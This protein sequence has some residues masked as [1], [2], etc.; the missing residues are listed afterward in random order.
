MQNIH[1][2]SGMPPNTVVNSDKRK[3]PDISRHPKNMGVQTASVDGVR[4][5]S[6]TSYN[7]QKIEQMLSDILSRL[8]RIE[9]RIDEI[10]YPPESDIKP[11]FIK[12]VKRAQYDIAEGKGKTYKS[13]E[14]FIRAI[15]E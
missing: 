15:S 13:M 8:E 3:S 2:D 14:D 12:R 10:V 11:E 1:L 7:D 5:A 6:L 9:K 4:E